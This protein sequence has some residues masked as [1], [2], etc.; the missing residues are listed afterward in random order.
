MN[1]TQI[2][3]LLADTTLKTTNEKDAIT[4]VRVFLDALEVT[5]TL[6]KTEIIQELG[7]IDKRFSQGFT[8]DYMEIT[9]DKVNWNG[10]VSIGRPRAKE[11]KENDLMLEVRFK[12]KL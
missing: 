2:A 3:E 5:D 8:L 11:V 4:F 10:Q 9:S 12:K 1:S 6:N 7:Q